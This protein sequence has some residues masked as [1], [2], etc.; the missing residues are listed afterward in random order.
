MQLLENLT[1][2]FSFSEP[3]DTFLLGVLVEMLKI[4]FCEEFN[5]LVSLNHF[6][7]NDKRKPFKIL[8]LNYG[9]NND[10]LGNI[11]LAS[12]CNNIRVK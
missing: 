6:H 10:L 2:F 8:N 3:Q 12:S 11:T 5:V 4:R 1:I 9:N 7:N